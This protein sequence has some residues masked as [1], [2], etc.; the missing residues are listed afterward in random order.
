[1]NTNYSDDPVMTLFSDQGER[2]YLNKEERKRFYKA[3]KIITDLSERTFVELIFWTGC[4]ISEALNLMIMRINVEDSFVVFKTLK[5][6]GKNKD[7]KFRIV[8]VPRKFMKKLER[9]HR[10]LE[11]LRNALADHARLLWRFGRQKGW[12][13]VKVVM[14]KA[15]IFGIRATPKGLRHTFGV[16]CILCG[17]PETR[18]KE[19]L[20]HA[21]LRTTNIYVKVAKREDR[22]FA[23]K[24]WAF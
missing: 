17:V 21:S 10:I 20:G 9:V 23:R 12:R 22:E 11:T 3:R 15:S 5:Q 24:T 8:H 6:H 4:R 18:L 13:L 7:K 14:T 2:K 16:H 1:M 19:W